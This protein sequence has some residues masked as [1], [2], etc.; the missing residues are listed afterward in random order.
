MSYKIARSLIK[1]NGLPGIAVEG[2]A[3]S[4]GEPGQAG[5]DPFGHIGLYAI[6][7]Y[8]IN[9]NAYFAELRGR[10]TGLRDHNLLVLKDAL[11]F[12]Q[13]ASAEVVPLSR[14][15]ATYHFLD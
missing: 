15:L 6:N 11:W 3:D 10:W 7:L 5:Q 12:P 8:A 9:G 14:Y 4:K 2:M 13:P 1:G